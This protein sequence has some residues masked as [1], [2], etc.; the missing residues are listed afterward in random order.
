M[1]YNV[2][3]VSIV[4]SESVSHVRHDI[5]SCPILCNTMDCTSVHGILWSRILEW[6][7]ISFSRESS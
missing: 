3:L 2:A 4:K 1:L 7:A 6:V 5:Q